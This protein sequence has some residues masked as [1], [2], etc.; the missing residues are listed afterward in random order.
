MTISQTG[1]NTEGAESTEVFF[2]NR[3]EG[4]EGNEE[5]HVPFVLFVFFCERLRSAILCALRVLC[6]STAPE[7]SRC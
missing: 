5:R 6:V 7:V 2:M 3:T 4:N 1:F